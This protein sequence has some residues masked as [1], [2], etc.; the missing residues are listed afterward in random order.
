MININNIAYLGVKI[1]GIDLDL[2]L[3][4]LQYIAVRSHCE[5]LVPT[6]DISLVDSIKFFDKYPITDATI[7]EILISRNSNTVVNWIKFK[8]F[9]VK[10]LKANNVSVYNITGVLNIPQYFSIKNIKSFNSNS[11]DVVSSICLSTGLNPPIIDITSDNQNWLC[12]NLT[13]A[14]FIVKHVLPHSYKSNSS[15]MQYYVSPTLYTI[16][17][18]D[19]A[20]KFLEPPIKILSNNTDDITAD[21]LISE[22]KVESS[23]G[24][25]NK[26]GGYGTKNAS[27]SLSS[28]ITNITSGIQASKTSNIDIDANLVGQTSK[29][30]FSALDIG[31]THLKFHLSYAQ[32]LRLKQLYSLKL[33]IL[34]R[35]YT[36]IEGFD[37]VN[38][39]IISTINSNQ[40]DEELSGKY[41]VMGKAQVGTT[42]EYVEKLCLIRQGTNLKV[43]GIL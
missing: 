25:N 34:V 42:G 1:N 30:I 21:F 31:N 28:G 29:T 16:L 8:K 37:I 24:A 2:T 32:N 14:D 43:R 7:I 3:I 15:W 27:Y 4:P 26:R 5:Y 13:Y 36:N 38:V 39:N 17:F 23:S 19:V 20:S 40:L 22:Y 11:S 6:L 41:I 18:K 35:N 33:D 9:A 12:D 10:Y